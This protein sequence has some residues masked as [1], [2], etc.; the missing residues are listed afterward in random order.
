MTGHSPTS[1]KPLIAA[2]LGQKP[3]RYPVWFMRQAGRYLPEYREIRA[4]LDFVQLCRTP[5]LAAEVTIQPLR[6]FDLDAAI[7]FSDILI[8]CTAMGQTLTFDKGHG[9]RLSNAVRDIASLKHLRH[10][11]VA[12]ELGYVGEA[13]SKTK[14]MLRADQ[15]MIGFAGAPFTVASYMI[16]G[17][18]SKEFTEVKKLLFTQPQVLAG[19]LEL[20]ADVTVDYL[21]MQ[22]AAGA[23][24]VMLFDTWA[25]QLTVADYVQHA[26]PVTN[27][28]LATMRSAGVPVIYYPGQG[29]DRLWELK[30][31]PANIISIDWRTRIDRAVS[32]L[33]DIGCQAGVQGNLDPQIM[34]APEQLIRSRTRAVVEAAKSARSHIFNV[35]H[36]LLPHTPPEALGWVVDELRRNQ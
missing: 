29:S 24:I 25:G 30:D 22:V 18:G 26:L 20:L 11:E 15:T 1:S 12:K 7:I 32:I 9:P 8:P 34:I 31:C 14:T 5:D 10:P 2:A 6:R 35:G 4:K 27:R 13:I 3:S 28:V 33:R 17:A 21:K 19:L 16:E 36:G 23:D